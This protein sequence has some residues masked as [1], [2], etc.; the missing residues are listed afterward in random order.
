MAVSVIDFMTVMNH[1]IYLMHDISRNNYKYIMWIE[2]LKNRK[3]DLQRCF[4]YKK[5]TFMLSYSLQNFH[6]H[7]SH[8]IDFRY[9]NQYY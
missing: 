5:S 8:K 3:N 1:F 2:E 7:R 4:C 6:I 9:A